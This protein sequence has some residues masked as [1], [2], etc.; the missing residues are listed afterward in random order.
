V[1]LR[2]Q[3]R[4]RS[5]YEYLWDSGQTSYNANLFGDLPDKLRLQLN[6][7]LKR[8]L[9]EKVP[10]FKLCSATGVIAL[11]QN[12]QPHIILPNDLIIRQGETADAMFF[13]SRG[14]VRVYVINNGERKDRQNV[15]DHYIVSLHEGSFFGEIALTD[16]RSTRTANVRAVSFCELQVL[17]A[18]DFKTTLDTYPDFKRAVELLAQSRM[19]TTETLNRQNKVAGKFGL[20]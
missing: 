1:P 7:A 19:R 9:I 11:V 17:S 8:R 12:L 2:L 20:G 5:Y 13:I 18:T 16:E 6:V 10:L 4:I 14:T 3:K 15:N